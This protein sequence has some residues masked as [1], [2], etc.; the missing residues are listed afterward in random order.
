MDRVTALAR[1]R[2]KGLLVPDVDEGL[3]VAEALPLA[4]A[5]D[6][7]GAAGELEQEHALPA[8]RAPGGAKVG[9]E[10]LALAK[11][12]EREVARDDEVGRRARGRHH[13]RAA[14]VDPLLL[15]GR[16]PGSVAL[17]PVAQRLGVEIEPERLV[18]PVALH[19]LAAEPERPAEILAEPAGVRPAQLAKDL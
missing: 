19:P 7:A 16:E 1:D 11:D 9:E 10:L 2:V 3:R 18:A 5:R 14:D 12:A 8:H 13:V 15:L 17:L 4:H 6:H